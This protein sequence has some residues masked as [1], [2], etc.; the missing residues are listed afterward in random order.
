MTT[1]EEWIDRITSVRRWKRAGERAPHKPLL[2]LY[3]LAQLQRTGSS[4]M[5]YRDAEGDLI[6]LLANYGPANRKSSPAYP[7]HRLQND[8]L[9]T[10]TADGEV[11]G[12]SVTKLRASGALGQFDPRLE[13][14]LCDSPALILR[15][16][17]S[18]L[19]LNFPES[20]HEELCAAV[21]LDRTG[22]E[23]SAVKERVLKLKRRDPQFRKI[24]LVAYEYRCAM[25]GFDGRMDARSVGIDAAHL[26][27]W[28][29]DGPDTVDNALCL[30][31]FHHK[32]LD[33]GV[34][35]I[36]ND[37]EMTV[38]AHFIGTGKAAE[39]LVLNLVGH[40]LREPQRGQPAPA[41]EHI[42]WHVEQVF[43]G[44]ARVA[45]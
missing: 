43:R 20:L 44:P 15:V 22:L 16:A 21:G 5:T 42:H 25:C 3:A 39:D 38:S 37:H 8:G 41:G 28:A 2:M 34:L 4:S 12:E 9:W 1:A 32:L 10:V 27:W 30:C 23:I 26:R 24:V 13:K 19:E 7:F 31:S 6:Q 17:Q 35:G 18:L 29:F 36:T 45:A 33:T 40:P 11:P 14:D